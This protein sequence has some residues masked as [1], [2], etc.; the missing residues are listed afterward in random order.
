MKK[1]KKSVFVLLSLCVVALALFAFI[2]FYQEKLN[3]N[4]VSFYV[5]AESKGQPSDELKIYPYYDGEGEKMYFFL[6][7]N[8]ESYEY[9]MFFGNAKELKIGEVSFSP[10]DILDDSFLN[11]YGKKN[12]GL[13]E[14]EFD[15]ELLDKKGEKVL[16][17]VFFLTGGEVSTMYLVSGKDSME[18]VDGDSLHNITATADYSVYDSLGAKETSGKLKISGHGNSTWTELMEEFPGQEFK[19][20]YN[21]SFNEKKSILGMKSAGNY[22]LLSNFY[23]ESELKNYLVLD[24]ARRIGVDNVPD[25]EYVNLYIN[26]E[27]RGLYLAAQKIKEGN[28]F[29]KISSDG[30]LAKFDYEERVKTEGSVYAETEGLFA[31]IQYPSEPDQERLA[32]IKEDICKV[33][34]SIK[35]GEEEFSDLADERSFIKYYLLQEFFE[36]G[37]ADRASQYV[38][39]NG[40]KDK[41]V[42]GPVWDFDLSMGHPWFSYGG[43]E[44][45]ALWIKG[46]V[47]ESGWL[48]K[49]SD[50]EAFM[51]KTRMFY[52]NN[53][54]EM[55]SYIEYHVLISVIESIKDSYYMDMIRYE[56]GP[57][58]YDRYDYEMHGAQK[59]DL[60]S[61]AED[62]QAWLCSRKSF[63]DDYADNPD[64]FEEEIQEPGENTRSIR[65]LILMIKK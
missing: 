55:V 60:F 10:G 34:D 38:Y 23:D 54:S 1:S 4:D 5:V 31:K 41:L 49:L 47:D 61:I 33:E 26:G 53:F 27:Y 36:N 20:S 28:G 30:Y 18:K 6:P 25:C 22:V 59:Y 39:K 21:I 58:Y 44:A 24:M 57:V 48:R 43:N 7:G 52:R 40:M 63:W 14:L 37:D 42:A 3:D 19:R 65:K 13:G 45:N 29:L 51:E 56:N 62:I 9:K 50:D 15:Y 32:Q 46:L 11:Y 64:Q 8:S 17:N 16:G 2:P 12:T 35:E